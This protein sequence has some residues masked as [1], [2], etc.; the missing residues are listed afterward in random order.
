MECRPDRGR[1]AR[2]QPVGTAAARLGIRFGRASR[3]VLSAGS[4]TAAGKR[5][6]VALY[7]IV[8]R[9]YVGEV[10]RSWPCRLVERTDPLLIFEGKFDRE[11]VHPHLG[12]IERGTISI[13]YFWLD[14]WFNVFRFHKP[15]GTFRNY[16]C[17]IAMPPTFD[18]SSLEFVDLDID[19]IVDSQGNI[20]IHD[21]DE[22]RE[23][24]VKFSYPPDIE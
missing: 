7:T 19:L 22:Y 1:L 18:E 15:N 23:N 21:E 8:S 12:Q 13:E 24:A 17:N 11:V 16:Y 4:P 3:A 14:R 6:M 2:L 9:N 10:R 20:S 5:L